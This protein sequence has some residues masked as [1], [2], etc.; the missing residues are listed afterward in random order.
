MK[1]LKHII[2]FESLLEDA[3]NELVRKAKDEGR[4]ALGYTCYHIP[5]VL[6]NLGNCFS[7]RL[8]A[9]KTGSMEMATYYMSNYTCEYAR[10]LLERAM[11]GGYNFLDGIGAAD[12]CEPINRCMEN[13]EI[14]KLT[15]NDKFFV[16][17]LDI[18]FA[19]DE[20]CVLH[21]KEQIERKIV[22][23]MKEKF[24][25]D[26]TDENLRKA[27]EEHNEVCRL[28][29]EIG[30]YRKEE[31]PRITGY[32]FHIINLVT[33]T[34]PKSEIIP[35]LKEIAEDLKTREPDKKPAYRV[36]IALVGSEI[37]DPELTKLIE[38]NGA[39]IVADRFC[40]GSIPGRQEI[41]LNDDEDV[42]TQ[43]CRDYLQTSECPRYMSQKKTEQRRETVRDLVKEYNADGIIYEQMK[44]CVFW[45]FE[46]TLASYIQ[47]NEYGIPCL[48]IDRPYMS[49]SSGQLRTRV[50]AFVESLEIKKINKNKK[51]AK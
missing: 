42:M 14:Q 29:K 50:Q 11:E 6:L 10:A 1:D 38:D 32:E 18:P 9:P 46:R 2:Y 12:T 20:D 24:G 21:Y 47:E 23:E 49:R 48:S 30:D 28:I 37:D 8:R 16:T 43:I 7:V 41:I 39:L 34:C 40:Y 36:K 44:F 4:L 51:E 17:H 5:E 3:N 13:W 25:I 45:G 35:Y 19:D 31:N 26:A 27:V 22:A 33:Y 15:A